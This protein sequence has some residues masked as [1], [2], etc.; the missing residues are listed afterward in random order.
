MKSETVIYQFISFWVILGGTVDVT[1]H[2]VVDGGGLEELHHAT[3]GAIGGTN[4]DQKFFKTL[5]DWLGE[6]VMKKFRLEHASDWLEFEKNFESKKRSIGRSSG[7]FITF[8]NLGELCRIYKEQ[9]GKSTSSRMTELNLQGKVKVMKENKF[10]FES[11]YLRQLVFDDPIS[12]LVNKLERL[13]LKPAFSDMETILLVGGFSDC[14]ILEQKIRDSFPTRN[15]IK[16][17]EANLAVMKGAVIFGHSPKMITQR[18]SPRYYGIAVNMP[19]ETGKHPETN[20]MRC[21]DG[22]VCTD[23]FRCMIEKNAPLTRIQKI[24]RPSS[25]HS[26]SV[27]I[28]VY[29]SEAPV[30]FCTDSRCRFLGRVVMDSNVL[31]EQWTRSQQKAEI[32]VSLEFGSTELYVIAKDKTTKKAVKAK[33]DCLSR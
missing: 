9:T 21:D 29:E 33:F 15:V 28:E 6:D 14:P 7:E 16:P 22:D 24:F 32:D 10:R 1:A 12:D 3:G 2:K 18:L 30:S 5:D 27:N 25:I 26:L 23:I 13:F 11:V 31:S 8:S 20:R 4:V 17:P 19:F